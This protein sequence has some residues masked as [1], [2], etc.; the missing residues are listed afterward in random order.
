MNTQR[1]NTVAIITV[2]LA[3]RAALWSFGIQL[4]RACVELGGLDASDR[5][6]W[7]RKE[8]KRGIINP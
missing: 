6:F 5:R 3:L 8:R 2:L 1:D 4:E 7:G